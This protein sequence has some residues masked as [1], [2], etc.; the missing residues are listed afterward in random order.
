[1]CHAA[2][3]DG[4]TVLLITKFGE[5]HIPEISAE[6]HTVAG[7]LSSCADLTSSTVAYG[8]LWYKTQHL[9]SQNM[10]CGCWCKAKLTVSFFIL[11]ETVYVSEI[12]QYLKLQNWGRWQA[13]GWILLINFYNYIKNKL[14][15]FSHYFTSRNNLLCSVDRNPPRFQTSTPM[16]KHGPTTCLA[17]T[18]VEVLRPRLRPCIH[19]RKAAIIWLTLAQKVSSWID[20]HT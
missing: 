8:M 2:A 10:D 6:A 19:G 13:F 20:I 3:M 17:W 1:M 5:Y 4:S 12:L 15:R 9:C 7:V 16:R 14:E 11:M 18:P